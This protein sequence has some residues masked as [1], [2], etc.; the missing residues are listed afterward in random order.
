MKKSLLAIALLA[1]LSAQVTTL[2]AYDLHS[3]ALVPI[4]EQAKPQGGTMRFVRDG[5][6]AFAIVADLTTER[7]KIGNSGASIQPA[8]NLLL[9]AFEKTTGRKPEVFDPADREKYAAYD[10]LLLVG[11][12]PLTR[13]NGIDIMKLAD[14][15]FA[16]KSFPKGLMIVGRDT[17][18]IPGYNQGR[19]DHLGTAYSTYWGA[20]DFT[21]RFLGCRYYFIGDLGKIWPKIADLAIAPVHYED[22]PYFRTRGNPYGFY[23]QVSTPQRR[24]Q[25]EPYMGKFDNPDTSIKDLWRLGG[26][27]PPHGKHYPDP[28]RFAKTL[29]P[30]QRDKVFFKDVKGRLWYNAGSHFGNYFDPVRLDGFA[31]IFC[32]AVRDYF[33][34]DGRDNPYQ[35]GGLVNNTYVNFGVCDTFLKLRDYEDLPIV[36]EL[37]LVTNE[38]KDLS[39]TEERG[40]MRN[41]YG[42]F[43][44]YM[45]NRLK[46]DCPGRKL[47]CLVYYNSLWAPTDPR[48]KLPDNIEV[49]VCDG[50]LLTWALSPEV[51]ER[52]KR[53]FGGWRDAL[54]GRPC[55]MAYLYDCG[56]P[57]A[58]PFV[59]QQMGLVPKIL[60]DRLGRDGVFFDK[61]VNYHLFWGYYVAAR[62]QWNPDIDPVAATEEAFDLC[63]G[64]AAGEHLKAFYHYLKPIVEET[65]IKTRAQS[66]KLTAGQI[67]RCEELLAKARAAVKPGTDEAR[68][69]ALIC[70][71][72]PGVFERERAIAD[73]RNP[74]YTVGKVADADVTLD[75][76]ADEAFWKDAADWTFMSIDAGKVP[77]VPTSAKVAWSE[78][79][80]YGYFESAERPFQQPD[81][82][83]WGNDTL[84]VFVSQGLGQEEWHQFGFDAL[85]RRY[86]ARKRELPI[87]QPR[88]DQFTGPGFQF[89]NAVADGRWTAEF[90]IPFACLWNPAAPGAGDR[91]M[92]NIV[93]TRVNDP[94]RL[95]GTALTLGDNA[96]MSLYDIITFR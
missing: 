54:Q 32:D 35:F 46:R 67:A 19:L 77:H 96:R 88:D 16:V 20:I 8:V 78:K 13:E 28:Q 21:E 3:K 56:N 57:V 92:L 94:K 29:T 39:K 60:G 30:E 74:E 71:Y 50:S 42:R 55:S 2:L 90:F 91:W 58:R 40:Q 44:Q 26:T 85:G 41:I 72:W 25:W 7:K 38:D 80:I 64:Q 62:A 27:R 93:K 49:I 81:K 68:R 18:L 17:A 65:M 34:S 48:W 84:E 23:T 66:V 1:T 63:C 79:G 75:G 22:A 11:D 5:E 24:A 73:Y 12:Q 95:D 9:E 69:C 47:Y 33:A 43:Y 36:K 61:G 37:G 52:A 87:P 70:D 53:L 10:Y 14:Q 4:T 15:G 76:R 89:A 31:D 6:P 45:G 86:T 59:A 83:M 51:Q 82:D